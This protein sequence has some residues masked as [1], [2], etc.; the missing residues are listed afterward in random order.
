MSALGE[1]KTLKKFIIKLNSSLLR[2]DKENV[3]FSD[4]NENLSTA[5]E[6]GIGTNTTLEELQLINL[7]FSNLLMDYIGKGLRDNKTLK[8]VN[9]S[10]NLMVSVSKI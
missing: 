8:R 5:I 3:V 2:E 1:T 10:G 7:R 4:R 6:N 9:V